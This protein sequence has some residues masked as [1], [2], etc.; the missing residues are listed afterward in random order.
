M[1]FFSSSWCRWLTAVCDCGTP[2]TFLLTFFKKSVIPYITKSAL[3]LQVKESYPDD[4]GRSQQKLSETCPNILWLVALVLTIPAS[5]ADAERGLSR[6]KKKKKQKKRS[7]L[8]DVHPSDQMAVMLESKNI[9]TF[10]PLPW[11]NLW[12][13]APR[14]SRRVK[15]IIETT[16]PVIMDSSSDSP[17]MNVEA[18]EVSHN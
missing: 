9:I 10:D 4:L 13:E 15:Q 16:E 5:S 2:W 3:L 18:D 11:I 8:L 6:L 14:V 7:R 12:N 17:V 1:S